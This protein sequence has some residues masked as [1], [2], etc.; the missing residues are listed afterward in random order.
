M[1]IFSVGEMKRRMDAFCEGL[2]ER[3]ADVALVHT[4]DNVF[5]MTGVPL[6]S[7]WGRPLWAVFDVEGRSTV[8]GS[9]IEK[10]NMEQ[11]S[12]TDNVQPYAD[13]ENVVDTSIKF[14][15]NLIGRHTNVRRIGVERSLLPLELFDKLSAAFPK[16]EMV[17]IGD[18]IAAC[19][20]IKSPEEGRILEIGG[21]IAKIG[22]TAFLDAIHENCTELEVA[23]HAVR[24]MN[25]AQAALFPEGGTSTYAYCHFGE[26]TLT[27]HHHP[28]GRRLR[29][30]EV[31]ALNVFPV[32]WGYCTELER[33]FIFGEPTREQQRALD[34][35]NEAFEAGKEAIGPGVKAADIDYLTRELLRQRGYENYIFHGTGHAHGIMIG[36]AGRE[37]LGE[38]RIYNQTVLRPNMYNSVEPAVFMEHQ[39]FRH[40]DVMHITETGARCITEFQRDFTYNG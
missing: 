23:A 2:T 5:Y 6:L 30:G 20:I 14:A 3:E 12:A 16:A 36:S 22:A 38:L 28:T 17:E 40:S 4:A 33:T 31:V 10:R 32:I 8:I 7:E 29:R 25:R 34:A 24:E 27:P 13:E 9:Y 18:I 35:I 26:H 15:T 1:A 21:T 19:R 39:A 11:N 37:E